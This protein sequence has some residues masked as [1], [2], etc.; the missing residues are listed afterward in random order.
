MRLKATF[1]NVKGMLWPGLFVNARLLIETKHNV[2][3]VPSTAVQRGPNGLYAYVVKRGSTVEM[4]PL[5]LDQFD[6]GRA[7][8][9][10]G[11]NP[12][13][14]VVVTGQYRLQAGARVHATN[15][16]VASAAPMHPSPRGGTP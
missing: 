9:E 5:T 6:A 3:T 16:D 4:R 1:P 7:I 10:D 8:V 13:E 15:S 12:G 2:L 14:Q 11:L